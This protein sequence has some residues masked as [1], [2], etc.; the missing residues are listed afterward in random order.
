MATNPTPTPEPTQVDPSAKIAELEAQVKSIG[1]NTSTGLSAIRDSIGRLEANPRLQPPPQPVATEEPDFFTDPRKATLATVGPA[2]DALARG[3]LNMQ[4]HFARQAI[5]RD[6]K[7]GRVMSKWGSEVDAIMAKEPALQQANPT[8][9]QYAAKSVLAD[10]LDEVT[11]AASK[12]QQFFVEPATSGAAPGGN[13][14]AP[15]RTLNEKE[16]KIAKLFGM[17][18][19]DYLKRQDEVLAGVQD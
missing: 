8:A 5:E 19:E 11:Q 7:L 12:G 16:T 1:E 9:W 14:P 15:K 3:Q 18:E 2:I 4:T 10:H 6:P 13:S 17:N